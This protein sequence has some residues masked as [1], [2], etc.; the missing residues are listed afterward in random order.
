M[1]NQPSNIPSVD[2]SA[3]GRPVVELVGQTRHT[4]ARIAIATA[5]GLI[6]NGVSPSDIVITTVDLDPYEDLL[7][8]AATRYGVTLAVWT[9]L[10]L[11]RTCPYQFAASLL[12]ALCELSNDSIDIKTLVEPLRFGW[13]P[14]YKQSVSEPLPTDIVEKLTDQYRGSTFSLTGWT[15]QIADSDLEREH[16]YLITGYLNWLRRQPQEPSPGAVSETLISTMESYETAILPSQVGSEPVSE[17]A[18]T[19]RGFDRTVE[20]L[21]TVEKRYDKWLDYGRTDRSWS[22]LD[23]LLDAFATTLP[24]RR[25]LPTAAAIDVKQAND[26]WALEVPYVIVVGLVDAEWPRSLDSAVPPASRAAV[27]H[28]E[29]THRSGVRPHSSWTTARDHD[30]FVSAASAAS[31]LL[32]ATRFATDPDGVDQNPSRF[33]ETVETTQIADGVDELVADSTELP[34]AIADCILSEGEQ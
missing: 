11:K 24:G 34:D 33:L 10:N 12:D 2:G 25:E 21:Q 19:L 18:D 30:H 8:R 9:P 26:L 22:T 31:K 32:V 20:L 6:E 5:A 14:P 16:K 29:M 1:T 23:K 4:E 17:L 7:E 3:S 15:Q 27:S 13:T 28:S